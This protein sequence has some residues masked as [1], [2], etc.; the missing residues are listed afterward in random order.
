MTPL[1][2]QLPEGTRF[3][4]LD[5]DE[6]RGQVFTHRVVV[7]RG[8]AAEG[9]VDWPASVRRLGPLQPWPFGAVHEIKVDPEAENYLYTTHEVPLHWD[10]AFK[11]E[12]PGILAF[13]CHRAPPQ[14]AGG[15]TVFVD[16]VALWNAAD[17]ATRER[18]RRGRYRYTTEKKAHYGGT[19]TSDVVGR[20]PITG[21]TVLRYAE[22]VDDLNP[23]AVEA[24]TEVGGL[25]ELLHTPGARYQHAWRD[26]DVVLAD[27]HA[28][29]HGRTAFVADAPR[30]LLRVNVLDDDG[31]WLTL[32]RDAL[33]IRR[34]EFG[35]AE[36]PIVLIP[37]G[38]LGPVDPVRAAGVVAV[39]WL[40]YQAGD[41]ANCLADREVDVAGKTA[42]AEA[43]RRLGV[44][45]VVAQIAASAVVALGLAAWLGLDIFA[46]TVLGILLA[47]QYSLPPIQAK[48]R[49]LLQLP[50]SASI[51]FVGPMLLVELALTGTMSLSMLA[52]A[53]AF[54]TMQQGALLINIVEDLRED[55][56]HGLRTAG[57]VLGWRGSVWGALLGNAAG[58]LALMALLA[59]RTPLWG[60]VPFV[61]AWSWVLWR[62]GDLVWQV[63]RFPDE[64]R[65]RL[66]KR[67]PELP[68]WLSWQAWMA[69][70]ATAV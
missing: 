13:Q 24:L 14:G 23:V 47:V 31:D 10:G 8:L 43:I 67:I 5:P 27:N 51:L 65:D 26:G 17:E 49:G 15:E 60:W 32:V 21:E 35:L 55:T 33:R 64:A 18:L 28:L 34:L 66:R 69:L 29:L 48:S 56:Q 7:L 42:L 44:R 41:M 22:P 16:T 12:I 3:A 4:D 11:G 57:V 70:V 2:R 61:L 38:L 20:H 53:V 62:I 39:L 63:E 9:P 46:A 54:G 25:H 50:Y 19:F 52:I 59:H 68:G 58:G 36:L 6:L 40:L 37:L 45:N 1:V 30:H